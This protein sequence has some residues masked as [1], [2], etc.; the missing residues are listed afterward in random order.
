MSKKTITIL[1]SNILL[2]DTCH[3]D[4]AVCYKI[5]DIQMMNPRL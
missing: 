2:T 5:D 1:C 3:C 4:D